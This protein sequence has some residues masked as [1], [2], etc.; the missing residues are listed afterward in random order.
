MSK[1]SPKARAKI[2]AKK[3]AGPK[4]SFPIED[5]AHAKAAILDAP[6]SERKGNITPMQEAMIDR[7][8]RKM[9]NK[10]EQGAKLPRG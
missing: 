9:L 10:N 5:K 1:L 8:A 6:K 7:R 3:F 4:R 2:P